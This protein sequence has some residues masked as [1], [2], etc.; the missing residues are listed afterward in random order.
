VT[1]NELHTESVGAGP[2]VVLAHGFTQTGRVWGS[3]S[4]LLAAG[5]RVVGVD[6]P[7]HAGSSAIDVDL[8]EGGAMLADAGG[9]EPFAL[10][11]YSLGARFALHA[12]L[13]DPARVRCLVLIGATPGIADSGARAE[14]RRRDEALA[15]GLERDGDVAAF[16]RT[17]LA[18][19]LFNGLYEPQIEER[20]RNTAAGLASSLRHAGT[21]TQAP[22]WDR[23]G[24][25]TTPTLVLAGAA[26]LRF[27]AIAI[28]MSGLLGDGVCSLIPG[29]GHPAHLEQPAVTA[30]LVSHFV[31]GR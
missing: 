20:L 11:G 26:D 28:R 14:R 4:T 27:A 6:L 24:E 25:L 19:P 15:A 22:L 17:W 7:G 8:V 2:T 12:A 5:H 31:D 3:F 18:G 1:P 30:R 13:S 21:G 9:T 29:A 16:V 23:L 10:V